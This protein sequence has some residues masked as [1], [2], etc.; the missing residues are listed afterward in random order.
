[1]NLDLLGR[2]RGIVA[3][4]AAVLAARCA[5]IAAGVWLMFSPAVIGYSGV[6]ANSVLTLRIASSAISSQ[7]APASG[8]ASI[9]PHHQCSAN[10]AIRPASTM[11]SSVT[12]RG[13]TRRFQNSWPK[14]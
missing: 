1:M 4:R 11:R 2:Q 10:A 7:S 3:P 9:L 6:P 13:P 12:G 14:T 5:A 8:L